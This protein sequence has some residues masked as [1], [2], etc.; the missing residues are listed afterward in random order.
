MLATSGCTARR[1]WLARGVLFERGPFL[2]APLASSD[3]WMA[4]FRDIEGNLL[5]LHGE[6][7]RP[8]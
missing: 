2:V 6:V 1:S 8:T 3:L 5:A 7:T 4:C